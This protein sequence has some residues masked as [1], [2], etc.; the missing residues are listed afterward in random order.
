MR[1]VDLMETFSA[2]AHSLIYLFDCR[3][4]RARSK[5]YWATS[6]PSYPVFHERIDS[7]IISRALADLPPRIWV[8]PASATGEHVSP[9]VLLDT[10]RPILVG[11]V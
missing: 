4:L 6:S 11:G 2:G 3:F 9:E 5:V 1:S 7:N 8:R 10:L